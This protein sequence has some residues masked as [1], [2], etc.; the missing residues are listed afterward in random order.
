MLKALFLLVFYS[1]AFWG[2]SQENLALNSADEV[3]Y[4][5]IFRQTGFVGSLSSYKI[6]DEKKTLCRLANNKYSVHELKSGVHLI[7]VKQ[8]YKKSRKMVKPVMIDAKPGKN[9]YLKVVMED[10]NVR[11]KSYIYCVEIQER[12]A[13]SLIEKL[14]EEQKCRKSIVSDP[15]L[16]FLSDFSLN[17]LY[18]MGKTAITH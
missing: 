11:F 15:K 16:T 17:F 18:F 6:L 2:Y 5:Y 10:D 3:A 9:Y 1:I 4:V 14:N 12:E 13:N 8:F 7:S